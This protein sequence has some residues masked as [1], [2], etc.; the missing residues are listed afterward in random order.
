MAGNRSVLM[1]DGDLGALFVLAQEFEQRGISL[2]PSAGARQARSLMT[3]LNL[4]IKVLV[5]NCNLAGVCGLARKMLRQNIGIEVIG[6][7]SGSDQ[8]GSCR[9]ILIDA[10]PDAEIRDAQWI[11]KMVRLVA[12]RMSRGPVKTALR[13][14]RS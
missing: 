4:R 2:I 11:R 1:V 7:V 5:V 14:T 3:K 9:E 13:A 6:I 10:L 8:C 12:G